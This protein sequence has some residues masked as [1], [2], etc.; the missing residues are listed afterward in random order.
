MSIS[1]RCLICSNY[2]PCIDHSE[3]EQEK[4]LNQNSAKVRELLKKQKY[5]EEC[6]KADVSIQRW[7][8]Y[9]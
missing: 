9:S 7:E 3:K 5:M 6:S 4:E 8:E 1:M 2:N